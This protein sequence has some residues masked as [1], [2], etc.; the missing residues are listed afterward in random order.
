MVKKI[1]NKFKGHIEDNGLWEAL[2]DDKKKKP[3][4]ERIVQKLFFAI[5]ENY[6]DANNL[7]ISPES[8]AGRGP[9]DFKISRGST[10]KVIVELKYSK[11]SG[12]YKNYRRQVETYRQAEKAKKGYYLVLLMDDN[13]D[14]LKELLKIKNKLVS[15]GRPNPE[16]I[17]ID[18]NPKVSA[19][20]L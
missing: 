17:F 3:V 9:V 4:K 12:L 13:Q 8:N 19:S 1:C 2:W 15:E 7:D 11:S 18:G 5:A 6:C 20:K 16:I 14:R 10:E